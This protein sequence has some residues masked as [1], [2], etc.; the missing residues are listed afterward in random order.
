MRL[1]KEEEE[2]HSTMWLERGVNMAEGA[3]GARDGE[4]VKSKV[5]V[6]GG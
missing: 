4:Y 2:K 6:V 3:G 1:A 5:V